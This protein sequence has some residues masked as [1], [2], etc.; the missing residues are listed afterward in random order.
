MGLNRQI[1]IQCTSFAQRYLKYNFVLYVL[2]LTLL[3]HGCVGDPVPTASENVIVS[4]DQYAIVAGDI[5]VTNTTSDVAI[6]LDSTGAFK[7][8]LYDVDNATETINGV[9]WLS[10]TEEVLV[11]V[12]G[13]DR[14]MAVS[15]VDGSVRTLILHPQLSGA[16]RGVMENIDGDILIIES[17]NLERFTTDAFRIT[18]GWPITNIMSTPQQVFPLSGGGFVMCATGTDRIRTFDSDGVQVDETASG[19]GGTTNSYGCVELDDGRIAGTWQGSNDSVV[20]YSS[21]LST[22]EMTY[23]NTALLGN[24]RGIDFRANGNLLIADAS[25]HYLVEI[26]SA[27]DYVG[28]IG[29]SVLSTPNQV[30]VIPTF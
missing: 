9:G 13:S 17:N 8:V 2:L 24:P 12:D 25:F 22:A 7:R 21:D 11:T 30:F 19:I 5:A 27:G 14:V 10:S 3:T 15:A 23:S 18:T 16:I 1:Y 6:L 29:G 26:T 20:I 4:K 28:N